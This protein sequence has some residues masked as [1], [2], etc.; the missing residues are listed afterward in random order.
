MQVHVRHS[1][2]EPHALARAIADLYGFPGTVRARLWRRRLAD[3]YLI[4]LS[5]TTYILKVYHHG[6]RT[7]P[8]VDAEIK[9]SLHLKERDV[10]VAAAAR[11]DVGVLDAPEGE[12]FCVLYDYVLGQS[13]YQKPTEK[14]AQQYGELI[15]KLHDALDDFADTRRPAW[16]ENSLL[17]H[18]LGII[19]PFLKKKDREFLE[20]SVDL[21]TTRL[22]GL[23]EGF[24]H[25]DIDPGNVL[26]DD[27]G[28]CKIYDF[29]FCGFGPR[30]YDLA[31]FLYEV[32]WAQWPERMGHAFLEGYGATD[33]FF[34][35]R[36]A[37]IR[38]LWFL[39]LVA[40]KIDDLGHY[41]LSHYYLDRHLNLLRRLMAETS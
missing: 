16:D 17:H 19:R 10:S 38:G 23:P 8:E 32:E 29:D 26:F 15:A 40:A 39:G 28:R 12:R 22:E 1:I 25:G 21:L 33:P 31:T 18:P 35:R 24:C 14:N 5:S 4:Y 11:P 30:A 9:F 36:L 6:W 7:K 2:F 41:E 34:L 27:K 37:P 3:V 20:K 13:L